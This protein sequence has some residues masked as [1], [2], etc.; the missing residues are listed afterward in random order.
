MGTG[1]HHGIA[2]YRRARS[3]SAQRHVAGV[4]AGGRRGRTTP[5]RAARLRPLPVSSRAR[6]GEPFRAGTRARPSGGA[7]NRVGDRSERIGLARSART[8]ELCV[9]RPALHAH[10]GSEGPRWSADFGQPIEEALRSRRHERSPGWVPDARRRMC[11]RRPTSVALPASAST[12]QWPAATGARPFDR[13]HS[14]HADTS[15]HTP[16]R[17]RKPYCRSSAASAV[18]TAEPTRFSSKYVI[19]RVR[20]MPSCAPTKATKTQMAPAT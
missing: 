8:R 18:R 1:A 2:G 6:R 11:G 13:H 19:D 4:H 16:S 10:T 15:A 17:S 20:N 14:A 7:V 3:R 12:R 5:M 9:Q